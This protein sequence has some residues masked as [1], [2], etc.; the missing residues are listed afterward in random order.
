MS[1]FRDSFR[2]NLAICALFGTFRSG[3]QILYRDR[4]FS[5]A[6]W[7]L[8]SAWRIGQC[9]YIEEADH[10]LRRCSCVEGYLL[11]NGRLPVC[12]SEITHT[13]SAAKMAYSSTLRVKRLA[14]AWIRKHQEVHESDTTE[15]DH[16]HG[17]QL[18][19]SEYRVLL[20]SP[21]RRAIV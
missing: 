6:R 13:K 21:L 3:K 14:L 2:A 20:R 10:R 16:I 18:W 8:M 9:K 7:K 4:I 11:Q 17:V 12:P 19:D 1:D 5:H 15:I